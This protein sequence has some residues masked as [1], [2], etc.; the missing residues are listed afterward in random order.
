MPGENGNMSETSKPKTPL[1]AYL[2]IAWMVI[3]AVFMVLELTVFG[4]A[5]DLN[6]SIELVL[7]VGSITGL[8]S[9]R[10]WGVALATFTLCYTL[11]TSMGNIIYYGI[12]AVNAPRVIINA[13]A[14]LYLFRSMFAGKFK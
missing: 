7:W 9:M 11:S 14:I 5:A 8:V 13:V 12:W 3:N 2:I 6:N 4:D 1:A 10:K